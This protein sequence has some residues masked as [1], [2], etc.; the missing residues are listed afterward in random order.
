MAKTENNTSSKKAKAGAVAPK[1]KSKPEGGMPLLLS[2]SGLKALFEAAGGRIANPVPQGFR[3]SPAG[4]RRMQEFAYTTACRLARSASVVKMYSGKSLTVGEKHMAT[5]VRIMLQQDAAG[6]STQDLPGQ[7]YCAR[8]SNRILKP[9][10]METLGSDKVRV[11][12]AAVKLASRAVLFATLA[13]AVELIEKAREGLVAKAGRKT[14][15]VVAVSAF[16]MPRVSDV[17]YIWGQYV[18]P[19]DDAEEE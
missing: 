3:L 2:A 7:V 13:F 9:T 15:Y 16:D 1:Q 12:A 19:T 10:A 6:L 18:A 17:G 5:A 8:L 11:A 14:A 4:R